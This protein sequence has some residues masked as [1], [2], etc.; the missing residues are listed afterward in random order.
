MGAVNAVATAAACGA[1]IV[2]WAL[3]IRLRGPGS[4]RWRTFTAWWALGAVLACAWWAV[5][6]LILSRV[7]PPFL[8][9]IE[10]SRVTTRWTSLVEVLRG[11]SS[12]TPFVSPDRVAG[13]EERPVGE[14]VAVGLVLHLPHR[15]LARPEMQCAGEESGRV[16]REVEL[17]VGGDPA[18]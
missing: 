9:F 1:A 10:S 18:G 7:S 2:W 3:H 11:T 16:D 4:R 15:G 13:E 14:Q 6:L 5:P 8:D 17:G 12:W